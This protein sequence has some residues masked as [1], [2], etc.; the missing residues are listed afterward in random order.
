MIDKAKK[1]AILT[2]WQKAIEEADA[3]FD[4]VVEILGLIPESPLIEAFWCTQSVLTDT[5][6][7]LLND[8]N[9]W[10]VWFWL[11]NDMGRKGL[12]AGTE[13]EKRPIRTLD[14]LIWV[15]EVAS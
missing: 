1:L 12:E 15:M 6:S 7:D 11:E 5:T 9:G 3:N 10:L 2:R 14:D 8:G 13:A 4:P